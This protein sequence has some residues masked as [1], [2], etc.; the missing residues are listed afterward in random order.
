[1]SRNAGKFNTTKLKGRK[2]KVD[3]FS[4]IRL[5]KTLN[6]TAQIFW[7]CS[8]WWERK[9]EQLLQSNLA[10]DVNTLLKYAYSLIGNIFSQVYQLEICK[11]VYK[12]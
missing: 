4:P 2:F 3:S 8:C 7:E 10:I 5:I 12:S 1:M 9:L 11:D 6:R